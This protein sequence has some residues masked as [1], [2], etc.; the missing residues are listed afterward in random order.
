LQLASGTPEGE[1]AIDQFRFNLA[2]ARGEIH[3]AREFAHQS[4]EAFDRLHLQ[5]RASVEAQ[6]ASVE[7]LA[8][9][10][11]AATTDA[12]DALRLSQ[13]QSVTGSVAGTLAILRQSQKALAIADQVQRDH[14]N[15]TLTINV[16]VPIIRAVAALRPATG[17]PDPARAIDFLNS[18][19]VYARD[20]AGVFFLRALA[21][22]QA[23]RYGEAQQDL[24]KVMQIKSHSGPDILIVEAQL[25]LGRVLQ[26]QGDSPNARIAYQNF[27]SSWKDADPDLP[28]LREAK[29]EY[30][31]LQ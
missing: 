13:A 14:P 5:G 26:K 6:L 9:D 20:N 3:Q 16:W 28:V 17:K 12:N 18:A 27:L 4:E 25:E 21:Y 30:A 7:A 24:Q 1:L 10:S 11:A 19:A 2:G 23:G 22:E 29:A 31:K 8:G 15:D